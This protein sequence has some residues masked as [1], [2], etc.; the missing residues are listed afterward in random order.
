MHGQSVMLRIRGRALRKLFGRLRGLRANTSGNAAMLVALGVPMLIG[1]SGLAVDMAQWYMWKREL[2]YAVDQSAIAGAWARAQTTTQDTYV[3]RAKQE[4]N[5]NLSTTSTFAGTPAVQLANYSGGNANSVVVTASATQSLPFTGLFLHSGVTVR[6]S[7]QASFQGGISYTSC[8]IATNPD[9]SGAITIGG[10]ATL[11]AGCGMAALST[12][13]SSIIVNGNPDVSS[14]YVLSKGGIDDWFNMHTN[15]EVHE[16]MSGLYDPFANLSPPDNPTPRTY[17]CVNGTTSTT[18]T[19]SVTTLVQN[20]T[21]NGTKSNK[22]TTLVSTTTVSNT[23]PVTTNNVSVP[24]GTTNGA[25]PGS[26]AVTTVTGSVTGPVS[27]TYTRVDKKTTVTT[28]YSNVAATTTQ[29]QAT[30]LPGTYKGGFKTTCTTVLTSGVYVIDGGGIDIDGQDQ[31]TGAGII[32][33]LKNGA[34]IKINGGSKI[35]LTAMTASQ[36]AL[37][38]ADPNLAGML[39]FEDRNSQ[40]SS[41]NNLNGNQY[42]V[43]NGTIY[44]PVSN[45]TFA[46]TAS[47][48]SQCLMIAANTITIQG[49]ANM[50]TFCPAGMTETTN[51]SGSTPTVRLVA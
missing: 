12:S 46:G 42:T 21:Y 30:M 38:G 44:L 35:T 48:T 40:G 15:D 1:G 8:L 36:L 22:V 11:T 3:T 2:Q 16:Y 33:V 9:D 4:F 10:N 32:F 14:G 37:I 25:A 41:K 43:L 20:L 51:V 23:G 13:P 24:N 26:P 27:G 6:V 7:A 47:V 18:A 49:T 28:T 5:S 31:V 39:V 50:S 45:L 29:T 17:N 34:Y 19:T